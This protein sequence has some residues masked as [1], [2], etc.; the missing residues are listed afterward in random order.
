M[1]DKELRELAQLNNYPDEH[2]D[3]LVQWGRRVLM[4]QR[5]FD[6]ELM[7]ENI[8][9]AVRNE[10]E[11]CAKEFDERDNGIGFYDPHEPAEIIRA[12]GKA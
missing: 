4:A 1:T 3:L 11:A 12:R 6:L 10:R 9:V 8:R 5:Q 2:M 7:T